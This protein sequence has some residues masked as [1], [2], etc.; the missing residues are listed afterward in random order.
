MKRNLIFSKVLF[1]SSHFLVA[2][3][4]RKTKLLFVSKWNFFGFHQSAEFV[5]FRRDNLLYKCYSLLI[6]VHNKNVVHARVH[7]GYYL[8]DALILSQIVF[9]CPQ[10]IVCSGAG[11]NQLKSPPPTQWCAR[12]ATTSPCSHPWPSMTQMSALW[13][14]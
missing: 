13:V 12:R 10:K 8:T 1:V 14:A 6:M 9:V 3:L 2:Q 4:I 11:P 5:L 7:T